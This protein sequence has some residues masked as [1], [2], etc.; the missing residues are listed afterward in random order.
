[1]NSFVTQS[2]LLG[3][4]PVVLN[5]L[6]ISRPAAGEPTLL[7]ITQGFGDALR[8][9]YQ[10]RP[11]I[12]ARR[13]VLPEMLYARVEEITERMAANGEVL[14]PLDE[15]D[16]RLKM[17]TA[18]DAGIPSV[19]IVLMHGYRFPAHE[20][21]L[22]AIAQVLGFAQ[23]SVSHEVSPLIKLVSRGD[24]TVVDAYLSPLLRRYVAQVAGDLKG[25]KLMF[26]QSNGG[27]TAADRFQ[28][29][30]AIL[31]GPAGGINGMA[32]T[33]EQALGQGARLIGFDMGGTST[34]VSHYAGRFELV[35]ESVV[36]GVRIRAPM[37][38]IHTVAAGGGSICRFDGMRFRVGPQSAGARPGPAC[39]RNGG[40]LT[41]TD[42]NLFLGRIEPERFPAVFGPDG[43]QPLD[44]DASRARLQEVADALG[45]A[46]S[47][48]AIAEGF[49]EIAVDNMAAAI[50][51]I[52]IARG[53]DVTLLPFYTPTLTDEERKVVET[54]DLGKIY[55]MGAHPVIVN[56]L[57]RSMGYRR[58]DYRP[59]LAE[60]AVTPGR[61]RWR[62]S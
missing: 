24:T 5:T 3:T 58:S 42:C 40:P 46:K 62:K 44:P 25:V 39:Y 15:S 53:H 21:R 2:R 18:H 55:A 45:N 41:V 16:A 14:V 57:A 23:I 29:K 13:I 50:R 61:T 1:M 26:M 34:D 48:E 7:L 12:F 32:R 19:A 30:D 47:L 37:M 43:D 20:R 27:L 36:A 22:K 49:L 6:N 10:N 38:Q 11:K 51:K 4:R 31:S 54:L 60:S 9:G 35:D 33:S 8:I 28:G 52:S 56:S 17:R 59:L